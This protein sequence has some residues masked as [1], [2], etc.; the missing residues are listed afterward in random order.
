MTHL[1]N[2]TRSKGVEHGGI[3]LRI[4]PLAEFLVKTRWSY[5]LWMVLMKNKYPARMFHSKM[6]HEQLYWI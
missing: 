1:G 3:S 6:V 5:L 4:G 2:L